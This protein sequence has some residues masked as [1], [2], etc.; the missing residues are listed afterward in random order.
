MPVGLSSIHYGE[1]YTE[2]GVFARK[3][4]SHERREIE[5]NLRF[6]SPNDVIIAAV[7]ETVEDVGKQ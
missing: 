7:G 4:V 1:I 5:S 3:A 2:Y 6:A